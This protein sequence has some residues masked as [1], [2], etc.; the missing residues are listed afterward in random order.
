MINK[1]SA[2]KEHCLLCA[3][4]QNCQKKFSLICGPYYHCPQ[5]VKDLTLYRKKDQT[6][7]D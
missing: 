1:E 5:F 3:W 6:I 4:R 2:E 7:K